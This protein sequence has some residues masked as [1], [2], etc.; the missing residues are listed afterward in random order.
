LVGWLRSQRFVVPIDPTT[1]LQAGSVPIEPRLKV[2]APL[3]ATGAL[4]HALADAGVTAVLMERTGPG[5]V[6]EF[7][8]PPARRN[9]L[10]AAIEKMGGKL[11]Q[12]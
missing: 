5:W 12:T 6:L 1:G 2:S 7:L 11:L 10:I 4:A 3:Y 8:T 9:K